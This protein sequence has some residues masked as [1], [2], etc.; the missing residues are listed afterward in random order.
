[1][2]IFELFVLLFDNLFVL[3]PQELSFF[4]KIGYDL[5]ETFLEQLDFGLH[6]L[7]LFCLFELFLRMLF[8]R[9]AFLLEFDL[10]LLVVQLKLSVPIVEV[11]QLF[12]LNLGFLV[13]SQV[14]FH[15]VLLYL[16]DVLLR[17]LDGIL[18]EVVQ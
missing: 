7:D 5:A 1:M 15:D 17:L 10:G 16:R 6:Q 2:E 12:F 4:L 13:Q 18:S 8:H 3:E 9:Q 14:L 11:R